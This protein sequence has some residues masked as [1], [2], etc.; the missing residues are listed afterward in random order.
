MSVL[1][2]ILH[3]YLMTPVGRIALNDNIFIFGDHF[4]YSHDLYVWS[5]SDN[6]R[7][8]DACHYWGLRDWKLVCA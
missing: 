8:N 1:L 2:T 5:S 6:V 4:F 7:R 3:I